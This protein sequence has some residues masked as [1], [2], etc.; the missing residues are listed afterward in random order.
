MRNKIVRI[1]TVPIGIGVRR[2]S[3]YCKINTETSNFSIT[4]IIG[5]LPSGNAL[6]GCGQIDMEFKHRNKIDDGVRYG[7][8]IKPSDINFTEGWNTK[9]WFDFL[10]VWKN[11]HLK[12]M[13]EIDICILKFIMDL[14]NTDKTP[15]W[16]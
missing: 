14:P 10:D 8:L 7:D 4:G 1:G 3:V 12:P 15:A 6:G 9:K 13:K 16:V 2:G 11:F 5:P